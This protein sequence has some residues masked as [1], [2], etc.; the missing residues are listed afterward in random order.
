MNCFQSLRVTIGVVVNWFWTAVDGSMFHKG[1]VRL[2]YFPS[3]L[4]MTLLEGPK[5]RW[6]DRV[7]STVILGALPF[8]SQTKKVFVLIFRTSINVLLLL[9]SWWRR[10]M[11]GQCYLTMKSMN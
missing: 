7:D 9:F 11:S 8:R 5:R 4:R 1:I 2:L 10:R 6:Y 3:I